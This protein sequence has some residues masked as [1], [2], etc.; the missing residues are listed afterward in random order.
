[1][2]SVDRQGLD[3]RRHLLEQIHR[4]APALE[5]TAGTRNLDGFARRAYELLA[6]PASREA[7]DLAK[8]PAKV[9]DCYG[10]TAL[11]QNCLLARRLVEAGVPLITVYSAGNRD[12]DTHGGNFQA[13]KNTLLPDTDRSVSALLNDLDSRGLLDETLVVWMGDMGRTPR[14][15]GAAGRDHW[16]F[17]YSIVM[18]GAGV[19]GGRVYGSSDRSAA[20][21]STNPVSPA[22]VVATIYHCLG[23]DPETHVRDQQGRPFIVSTGKPVHALLG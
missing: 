21:P 15:N 17:C 22:D 13:L 3:E 8:E 19:R 9:R 4:V 14:I 7:F 20:Y 10:P 12:W 18:A 11:G 16:S 2:G 6:S 23:I 5:A 1:M